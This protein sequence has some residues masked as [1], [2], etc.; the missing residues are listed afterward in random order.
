MTEGTGAFRDTF[1]GSVTAAVIARGSVRHAGLG[2]P[3]VSPDGRFIAA[4]EHAGGPASLDADAPL[5]GR[6]LGGVSLW[7][8][9]VEAEAD[10]P[11]A[12]GGGGIDAAA[13]PVALQDAS[14]PTFGPDGR[15][16]SVSVGPGGDALLRYDPVD[17]SLRRLATGLKRIAFPSPDPTGRYVAVSGFGGN[18]EAATLFLVDVPA[19]RATPG[20][21][22][23]SGGRGQV[24][25][26]WEAPGVVLFVELREGP[27]GAPSPAAL[28]RWRVGESS[29]AD[30]ASLPVL[31]SVFDAG[32][33]YAGVADPIGPGGR[34]L[35]FFDPAAEPPGLRRVDLATGGVEPVAAG[36]TAAASWDAD[37]LVVAVQPASENRGLA[38]EAGLRLLELAPGN[39]G[40]VTLLP[41]DWAP[42]RVEPR[43]GGG[44]AI[45]AV[46]PGER[47]DRLKLV[48]LFVVP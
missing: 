3:V 13:V 16:W 7:V 32:S 47:P 22:P 39:R 27:D 15:L 19:G 14:F 4:L 28:R 18:P 35:V 34:Y 1:E 6:G 33:L 20:P 42:L 12:P 43:A 46:A 37:R 17:G 45:L 23:G 41:G 30:V 25:P 40:S 36:G 29:A 24:L 8:R 44:A 11:A 9:A 38:K 26:R 2:L 48:Q 31:P 21:P 10:R 5:L